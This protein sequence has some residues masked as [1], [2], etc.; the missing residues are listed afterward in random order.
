MRT[1]ATAAD[2]YVFTGGEQPVNEND[3]PVTDRE[4]N[5]LLRRASIQVES[6]V[7]LARY[8][9]D[10]DGYPVD[11]DV[12]EAMTEATCAQVTWWDETGDVTGADAISGV[13]KI[14][15]VSLGSGNTAGGQRSP[16]EAR[17]SA[18]A[19]TI[20]ENAGLITAFVAH[21]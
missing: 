13:T 14:L 17:A 2:Y 12:S 6:Y 20:L 18:E 15:S 19:I 4:L 3:E 11:P 10:D 8:D 5:A 16:A 1:Y 21:T 7:R 9:T